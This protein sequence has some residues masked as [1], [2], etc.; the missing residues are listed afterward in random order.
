MSDLHWHAAVGPQHHTQATLFSLLGTCG[1]GYRHTM[2]T[3]REDRIC[4][5]V[6][7][8]WPPGRV[9]VLCGLD[10]RVPRTPEVTFDPALGGF[11]VP[12]RSESCIY[13]TSLAANPQLLADHQS[14]AHQET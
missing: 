14:L 5:G 1:C 2:R 12:G 10:W 11:L 13:C 7:H 8:I 4:P 3:A 6:A 9:C